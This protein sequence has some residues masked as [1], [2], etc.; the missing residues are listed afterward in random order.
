MERSFDTAVV[1]CADYGDN[2]KGALCQALDAIDGLAFVKEGMTVA[3][4]ANLVT[5]AKP[6]TATTVHPR[7][8]E[9]LCRLLTDRGARVI[10]GDSPG[11]LYNEAVL[12]HVYKVA[13]LL[14][15]EREGVSL[16]RNFGEKDTAYPEGKVLHSF[17][18]TAY[19]DEADV[20]VNVAKLKCH[21]MMGMSA[22]AKNLFGVIPGTMKPE[23]H[24][25]FPNMSDFSHM[26][27]DINDYF[28]EKVKICLVD[29][30]EGM[31]GNGP[32]KGTPRH[33]GL[34]LG[35]VSPHAADAVCCRLIGLSEDAVPT[36]PAARERGL[37]PDE[38][39]LLTVGIAD[40]KTADDYAVKDFEHVAVR[41][42]HLFAS[43][44]KLISNV[45]GKLLTSRPQ[46]K[47]SE[48]V[49]CAKCA[50]ICPA[51]AITMEN[52]KAVIDRDKCIRCFCC[53]E[54]CPTGAMKVYRTWIARMLV[55]SK[56]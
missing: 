44:G 45:L 38:V 10:I 14:P 13:G 43:R 56:R 47:A 6:D 22:A 25:R 41:H 33:I 21:G 49:G 24:F 8:L 17:R 31:E 20:I 39:N 4:K 54:F 37:L 40:E 16:N 27:V 5:A 35:S 53:Q 9:E 19:L 51:K 29:A 48:C 11:G 32:T 15:L 12:S 42:G 28:A 46:L 50:H 26:L 3:I 55:K 1:P 2:L 34:L 23:Y 52:K 18:Y 36:L 7:L 30:V